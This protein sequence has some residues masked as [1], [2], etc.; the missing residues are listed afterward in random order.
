MFGKHDLQTIHERLNLEL[1]GKHR[2]TPRAEKAVSRSAVFPAKVN[3]F[4]EILDR[5]R[6]APRPM[7]SGVPLNFLEREFTLTTTDVQQIP[8]SYQL[9]EVQVVDGH[10]LVNEEPQLRSSFDNRQRCYRWSRAIS[11]QVF[12]HGMLNVDLAGVSGHGVILLAD[13][14]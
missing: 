3:S 14:P 6:N 5:L 8:R 12:E 7:P 11:P 4:D 13:S 1:F 9:P 2:H 10:I